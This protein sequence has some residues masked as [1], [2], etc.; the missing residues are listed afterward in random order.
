MEIGGEVRRADVAEKIQDA[1]EGDKGEEMRRR[2][3]E[4]KDKA[5]RATLPG[6]AAEVNLDRLIHILRGKIGQ[7]VNPSAAGN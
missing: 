3:A 7:A 2:S 5:A 1:M 4:W 6:G